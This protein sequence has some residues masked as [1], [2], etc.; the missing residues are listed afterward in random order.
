MQGP[1]VYSNLPPN[2]QAQQRMPGHVLDRLVYF[3]LPIVM[4]ILV[5]ASMFWLQWAS[6]RSVT[7]GYP[8]PHVALFSSA[9]NNSVPVRNA[10]QFS[11]DSPGRGLTYSWN[12]GDN[13]FGSGTA[14]SH[15]YQSGGS[16]TVT[17]TVTDALNQSSTASQ[18]VTVTVPPPQASFTYTYTSGY[19]YITYTFDASGST[20]DPSTSISTYSWDFGDQYPN[21][22][23]YQQVSHSYYYSGTY[24]ITL[25]V[26]DALGQSSNQYTQTITI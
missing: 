24:T 5:G 17:V 22:N 7:L 12:Y 13:T 1:V 2:Q 10:I 18:Q 11:A 14:V 3:I 4:V 8:T 25:V 20:V 16:Y 23:G 15:N 26:T 6:Q 9:G 21:S 19:G